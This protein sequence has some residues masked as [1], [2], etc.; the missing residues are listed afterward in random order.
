LRGRLE[1]GRHRLERRGTCRAGTAYLQGWHDV[2]SLTIERLRHEHNDFHKLTMHSG[3]RKLNLIRTRQNG[4]E[5][6]GWKGVEPEVLALFL[7]RHVPVD[8]Q[9]V[10]ARQGRAFSTKE[11]NTR[12]ERLLKRLRDSQQCLNVLGTLGIFLL[13]FSRFAIGV[14]ASAATMVIFALV[15]GVFYVLHRDARVSHAP[16]EQ[17]APADSA[18]SFVA[19]PCCVPNC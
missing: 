12:R 2:S 4:L 18:D 9:L 19:D 16:S 11:W 8:K 15:G 13:A 17:D 6:R 10:L 5:N 14:G 3:K 1:T 7:L